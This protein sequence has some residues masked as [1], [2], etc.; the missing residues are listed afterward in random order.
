MANPIGAPLPTPRD[1]E[2]KDTFV[3]RCHESL[4]TEYPDTEQRNAICF[5]QWDASVARS[6]TTANTT[7]QLPVLRLPE[8][9]SAKVPPETIPVAT[10]NT[11]LAKYPRVIRFVQETPW[12]ILP[13]TLEVIVGL[14]RFRAGGGRFS[15]EE[16]AERL[17]FALQAAE[18]RRQ[19][20][21][22]PGAVAVIPLQ[23]PIVQRMNLVADVSGGTST[24]EFSA[25]VAQAAGD[26]SVQGIVLD[27][28]SP[29]GAVHGLTEAADVIRAAR[30]RKP[31]VAV[32]NPLIASAAYWLA[33]QADE[34]V[35]TPSAEV[36]AIGVIGVHQDLTQAEAD[37]GVKTTYVTA[38]KYKTEGLPIA[39]TDEARA[40]MQARVDAFYEMFVGDV[41]KGRGVTA[42]AVREGYGQG[43]ML[44][45][46]EAIKSNL[47]DRVGSLGETVRSL[48]LGQGPLHRRS[49]A[50]AERALTPRPVAAPRGVVVTLPTASYG[51]EARRTSDLD[52]A[53]PWWRVR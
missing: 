23:G 28:D 41:A 7:T 39:L 29:G 49:R 52:S 25:A 21:T 8:T 24:E 35:M 5:S 4:A 15:Q 44:M 32:A 17:G 14:V 13:S 27:V 46:G 47:A 9:F 26:P 22:Q 36:G 20:A 38:G 40:A 16:L 45:A 6:A 19:A 34:I 50:L 42:S 3:S 10:T 12:A 33:S 30:E 2:S 18:S 31:V 53:A 51:T 43:R 11:A 48:L 1:G 37:E